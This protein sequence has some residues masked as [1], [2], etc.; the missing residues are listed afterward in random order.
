MSP[1]NRREFLQGGAAAVGGAALTAGGRAVW[2]RAHER[3]AD[4]LGRSTEQ[5]RGQRQAGVATPAQ[6]FATWAAFDL[7]PGV[8]RAALIR[9]MRVWTD[10]AERLTQGRP[11][12]ADTEPELAT[13][14]ARLTV[15]LGLGAGAFEAAG[16]G[17][18]RPAWLGPLP[19]F[20]VDRLVERWTGGDLVLQV[21]ADDPMTL[22]H[23]LRVLTKGATTFVTPRWT[24]QGFREAAGTRPP[25]TTMRNLMGQVDGTANPDPAAE[26]D[27]IWHGSTS[28]QW[29]VGSTSLVIRRIAMD[30]DSWDRVDRTGREF[31]IGRRLDTGAPL[32]GSHERDAPDLTAVD[33]LGLPVIDPAAHIRRA[34]GASPGERF[35]RRPYS[36]HDPDQPAATASGLLFATYQRDVAAQFI[37]VQRRL[38]EL[39]L[40]NQW[41]TP[42]GSAVFW[43]PPGARTG[44]YLAQGLLDRGV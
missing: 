30:L 7:R 13:A 24:Q 41:T 6:T 8:D 43:V 26:P 39:D 40:L 11:A 20:A 4:Q 36:Y 44:E 31:T 28:P 19:Q 9:L 3:P 12:L 2:D 18:L 34:A 23:A 21:A 10:D 1:L 37:P 25:G 27:L 16:L 29:L 35:L 5:F 14:P 32:T 38:A 22:T 42:I 33:A 17:H 15:T